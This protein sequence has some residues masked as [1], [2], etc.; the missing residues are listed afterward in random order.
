MPSSLHFFTLSFVDPLLEA[1]YRSRELA[2]LRLHG[3]V[4]IAVGLF[5]YALAGLLDVYLVA[6]SL[7][8]QV[9]LIRGIAMAPALLTWWLIGRP[10]FQRVGSFSLALTGLYLGLGMI[11]AW[12]LLPAEVV[13][14]HFP[15]MVLV[16]LFTYNAVGARFIHALS[17]GVVLFV[18]F[19]LVFAGMRLMPAG[20]LFM[21]DFFLVSANL[22]GG[23]AAFLTEQRHRLRFLR[24]HELDRER[25]LQEQRALHDRLTGLPN[26]ELLA[27]R[28]EQALIL[29]RRERTLGAGYFIDL[30]G[31]KEVND[32]W[33]HAV[34]DQLLVAVSGRLQATVRQ[35]DT[36]CRLGGDEFF[37][38]ARNLSGVGEALGLG[39]KIVARLRE[40]FVIGHRPGVLKVGATAGVCLFPYPQ[41]KA[42][43]IIR[44]AD[45]AMYQ[46]KQFGKNRTVLYEPFVPNGV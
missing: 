13:Q 14:Y 44:R 18:L 36:V 9:W 5:L 43:D 7:L 27:D 41:A 35:A 1:A 12:Y 37:V 4:A 38:L 6:P 20:Q 46:G 11:A 16:I 31:F 45:Q 40:P 8:G 23:V 39:D 15:G 10:I 32:T 19:N 28:L 3:R 21:H 2:R 24:E 29:A 25:H 30:D 33:G 42:N 17:I 22:I 34:G 26:R